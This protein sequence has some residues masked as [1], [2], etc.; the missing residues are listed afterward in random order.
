MD[1][2]DKLEGPAIS[3]VTRKILRRQ[4]VFKHLSIFCETLSPTVSHI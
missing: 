1:L 3:A 4:F 2:M